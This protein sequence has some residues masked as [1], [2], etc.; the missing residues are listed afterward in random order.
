MRNPGMSVPRRVSIVAL[1]VVLG[2]R[3]LSAQ[4]PASYRVRVDSIAAELART[5]KEQ[6]QRDSIARTQQP[7]DTVRVGAFTIV[8]DSLISGVVRRSAA[9]A[10]ASIVR[11]VGAGRTALDTVVFAAIP[12]R[13][14]SGRRPR[15]LLLARLDRRGRLGAQTSQYLDETTLTKVWEGRAGTV[16]STAAGVELSVWLKGEMPVADGEDEWRDARVELV[17]ARAAIARACFRGETR[18]C[19]S[20]LALMPSD[21]PLFDWY[22]AEER[23]DFLRRFPH[24]FRRDQNAARFDACVRGNDTEACDEVARQAGSGVIEAPLGQASRRSL[25]LEALELGGANA[26]ERLVHSNGTLESR[27]AAAAGVSSDSLL[28]AWQTRV[29]RARG[30]EGPLNTS[31]AVASLCWVTLCA[32]LA[33]RSSRWR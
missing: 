19:A 6:A 13:D 9:R 26:Y 3:A 11:T 12:P 18:Q 24:M 5:E 17:T 28:R 22:D 7:S 15:T 32:L 33:L 31:T 8:T 29:T 30:A 2:G 10:N 23:R 20:A 4:T 25:V 1:A 27:L 16:L 14:S 21:A